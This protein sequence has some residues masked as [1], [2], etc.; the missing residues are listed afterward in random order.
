M[1]WPGVVRLAE[2]PVCEQ[3]ARV[4]EDDRT[5]RMIV[6]KSGLLR[7]LFAARPVIVA[8]QERDVLASTGEKSVETVLHEPAVLFLE[9]EA[10]PIGMTRGIAEHD[11]TSPV[12]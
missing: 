4:M 11:L 9:D 3:H 12:G 6:E 8:V 2:R 5:L 1:I 10:N 7:E